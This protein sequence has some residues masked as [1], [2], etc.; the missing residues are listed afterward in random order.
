[1]EKSIKEILKMGKETVQ[2]NYFILIKIFMKEI[3]ET[4]KEMVEES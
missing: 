3:S 2:V 1:M 4:E